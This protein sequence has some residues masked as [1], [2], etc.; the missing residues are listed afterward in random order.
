[1]RRSELRLKLSA[2]VSDPRLRTALKLS[3]VA[4]G[5]LAVDEAT[6]MELKSAF[7]RDTSDARLGFQLERALRDVEDHPGLVSFYETA[8]ETVSDPTEKLG[9][10]LRIA[11]LA[12]RKLKDAQKALVFYRRALELNPQLMPALQGVRRCSLLTEDY[13]S[14]CSALEAQGWASRD[15]RSALEAFVTA[16]RI[17]ME[18]LKDLDAAG[19]NLRRALERDPLDHSAAAG[20]REILG[21]ANPEDL[22]AF[23]E[24]LGEARLAQK[25]LPTASAEFLLAAR[26]WMEKANDHAMA[27][28][29]VERALAA[30]PTHPEALELKGDLGLEANQFAEGAAAFAARVQQGGEASALVP[31]HLKLAALYHDHLSDSTRAAAHLQT[32]LSTDARNVEALERLAAICAAGRNWTGAA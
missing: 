25:E 3:A 23:H 22:A 11:D 5:G 31:I 30:Q 32:V 6:R 17:A 12:E 28:R 7:A 10:I 16:G 15:A 4:D 19:A 13:A 2:A 21:Q 26:T 9:L 14:A 20:L 29:A 24:R 18:K 27:L 1:V 8:L